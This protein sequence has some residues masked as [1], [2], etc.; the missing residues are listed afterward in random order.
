MPL[1][2]SLPCGVAQHARPP[3]QLHQAQRVEPADSGREFG[4]AWN[5]QDSSKADFFDGAAVRVIK[6][7]DQTTYVLGLVLLGNDTRCD[8]PSATTRFTACSRIASCNG[9]SIIDSSDRRFRH[10]TKH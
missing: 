6:A 5:G 8:S 1:L 3:P 7:A 9:L 10:S 4:K 2:I